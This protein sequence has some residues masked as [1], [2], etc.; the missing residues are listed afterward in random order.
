M[1]AAKPLDKDKLAYSINEACAALSLGTSKLYELM[2][3]GKLKA[4][5]EGARTIIPRQSMLDYIA[6]LPDWRPGVQGK[7]RNAA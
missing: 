6:S 2:R 5:A 7:R 3:D 1:T 4:K